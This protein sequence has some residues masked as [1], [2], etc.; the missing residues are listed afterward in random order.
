MPVN[1]QEMSA[2]GDSN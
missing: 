2:T 1:S